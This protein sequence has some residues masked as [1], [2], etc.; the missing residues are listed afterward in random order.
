MTP[1]S[2]AKQDQSWVLSIPNIHDV[3]VFFSSLAGPLAMDASSVAT[4]E[5]THH[6]CFVFF[7]NG[8]PKHKQ[9][10]RMKQQ[11]GWAKAYRGAKTQKKKNSKLH[12]QK[13]ASK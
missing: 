5:T 4:K 13:A 3:E 6:A 1:N 10:F 9:L 12:L 2:N 7:T 8:V 11:H